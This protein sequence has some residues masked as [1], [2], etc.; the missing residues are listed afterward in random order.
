S[1]W[2]VII[3]LK[4]WLARPLIEL[5][6]V[7][8]SVGVGLG[9][10]ELGVGVGEADGLG[11]GV[12][13]GPPSPPSPSQLTSQAFAGR[14]CAAISTSESPATSAIEAISLSAPRFM[15]SARTTWR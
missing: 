15:V 11:D 12:G 13:V 14:V 7:P 9:K 8:P 2:L 6:L 4:R 3:W 10:V 5:P 1:T